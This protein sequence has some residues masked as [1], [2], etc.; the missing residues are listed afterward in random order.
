MNCRFSFQCSRTVITINNQK[1]PRVPVDEKLTA[2]HW[3]ND[4]TDA[5]A[6]LTIWS[7]MSSFHASIILLII[8]QW[9][10]A[11]FWS[12]LPK[13]NNE[14]MI[15]PWERDDCLSLIIMEHIS[16]NCDRKEKLS[17]QKRQ[18]DKNFAEYY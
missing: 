2:N 11:E 5:V 3:S 16:F 1:L 17:L 4:K 12:S 9:N 15:I 10:V 7:L 13:D 6:K 18:L 8:Y 14:S